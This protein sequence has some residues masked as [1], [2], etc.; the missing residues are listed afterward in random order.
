MPFAYNV[1]SN[2]IL[3]TKHEAKDRL[4]KEYKYNINATRALE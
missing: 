2:E 1:D 4:I 3:Y